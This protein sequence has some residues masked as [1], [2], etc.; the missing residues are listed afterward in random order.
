MK[1]NKNLTSYRYGGGGKRTSKIIQKGEQIGLI[2]LLSITSEKR[3]L[4]VRG[5]LIG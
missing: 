3:R 5:D 4:I 2:T 1:Y